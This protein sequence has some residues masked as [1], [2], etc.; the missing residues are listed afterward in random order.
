MK[1]LNNHIEGLNNTI[2][3]L[4]K[5]ITGLQNQNEQK[6]N[7]IQ[8]QNLKINRLEEMTC[9]LKD[10]AFRPDLREMLKIFRSKVYL[11]LF[12]SISYTLILFL[13][14]HVVG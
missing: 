1:G 9:H 6:E 2:E 14:L 3:Q 12:Y 5:N 7:I 13:L 11:I 10:K 4:R 8:E